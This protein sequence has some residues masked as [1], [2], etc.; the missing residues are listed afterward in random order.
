MIAGLAVLLLVTIGTVEPAVTEPDR[1]NPESAGSS[2]GRLPLAFEANRGQTTDQVDFLARGPGYVLFLTPGSSVFK[3]R[4]GEEDYEVA[5]I[6]LVGANPSPEATGQEK[7]PGKSN[8][9]IGSDPTRWR[10]GIPN[11]ARVYYDNVY[12]GVDLVYYGVEGQLEYDFLVSPGADSG[13]IAFE[14]PGSDRII[15]GGT[16]DLT[17]SSGDADLV[18]KNPV[19]YQETGNVRQYIDGG[20]TLDG[21]RVSFWLGSYDPSLPLVIDPIVLYT[22]YLGGSNLDKAFDVDVDIVHNAYVVGVALSSDFP[23]ASPLQAISGAF[24]DV[25]IT[26]VKSDGTSLLYSTYLGGNG[27]DWGLAIDVDS[28]G[29]A[30]ITGKTTSSDFPTMNPF[31]GTHGGF[32]FDDAFAAKLNPTGSALVYSTYLGGSDVDIGNDIVADS[33]GNAIV[34]GE[35]ASVDLPSTGGAL[36][37]ARS[38]GVDAFVASLNAAG[39]SLNYLTY[40]GG[41]DEDIANGAAVDTGGNAYVIGRTASANFPTTAGAFQTTHSG[42]SAAQVTAAL[43]N[44]VF[45]SKIDPTG[46]TL[47]YSTF[48]GG[49]FGQEVGYDVDVDLSGNAYVTGWTAS[50]S[51][52]TVNAFQSTKNAG[53]DAFVAKVAPDASSLVWSTFLGGDHTDE[54]YAIDVDGGGNIYVGGRTFSTD[55]PVQNA[56]RSTVDSTPDGFVAKFNNAGTSLLFST[57]FGGDGTDIIHGLATDITGAI[58]VAGESSSVSTFPFARP[59]DLL[60]IPFDTSQNGGGFDGFVS[61][62]GEPG[63]LQ[64]QQDQFGAKEGDGTIIITIERTGGSSGE[65]TVGVAT[66]DGTAVAETD[67]TATTTV[68][69]FGDG[70]TEDKDVVIVLKDDGTSEADETFTLELANPTGG[71]SL[72]TN[73]DTTVVI[74][75]DDIDPEAV[76]GLSQW[77]LMALGIMLLAVFMLKLR[78]RA[79]VKAG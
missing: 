62:I 9:F 48:L 65:V 42:G 43:L 11:Y 58:Y 56:I 57:Y 46:A 1:V 19:I 16:G 8:Y 23:T 70:D 26:K 34:V 18:L 79:R 3:L 10:T 33:S 22:T 52:P 71:A 39:S 31:D 5:S 66:K 25:F 75:N 21:S 29:N 72:G 37:G 40:L 45:L 27:V 15:L 20:Y 28:T 55:F 13:A 74:E 67:Y 38:L 17:V 49:I 2:Y 77:G 61:K 12:P 51:F 35:T 47:S 4:T 14:I 60:P 24:H 30:Y 54:S 69:K 32:G 36:Q 78:P 68:V 76:P 7:L 44:D 50:G 63:S 53:I 6:G 64:F 41:T 59:E 73:D